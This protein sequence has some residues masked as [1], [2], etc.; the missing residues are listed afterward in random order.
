MTILYHGG[1]GETLNLFFIYTLFFNPELQSPSPYT[2]CLNV[3]PNYR[4]LYLHYY[5]N[6]EHSQKS[7]LAG[8]F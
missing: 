3:Y 1:I 2:F 5:Y 6:I 4:V 8:E 7:W